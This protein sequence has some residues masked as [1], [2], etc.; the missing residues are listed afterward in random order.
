[1]PQRKDDASTDLAGRQGDID[2]VLA[3]ATRCLAPGKID[4]LI[5]HWLRD[6]LPADD[7][8]ADVMLTRMA[9]G[10]AIG[11]TLAVFTPSPSGQTAFDRLARQR[12]VAP[13]LV[14]VLDCLRRT[15][16]RVV[17]AESLRGDGLADVRDVASGD[18]LRVADDGFRSEVMGVRLA[19]WVVPG[20]DDRHVF[21]GPVVPLDDPAFAVVEAFLRTGHR[22]LVNPLRCAD[23]VYQHVVHHGPMRLPAWDDNDLDPFDDDDPLAL[24][25]RKWARTPAPRSSDD[26]QLV[27][28]QSDIETVVCVLIA[29]GS[30][31][32][33]RQ[34]ALAAA[35]TE[36]G[37]V[38]SETIDRRAAIS[39]S[40]AGLDDLEHLIGRLIA[41]KE[42]PSSVREILREIRQAVAGRRKKT[43]SDRRDDLDDVIARIQAL[44]VRTVER[45]C[46]EQEVLA[47]AEKAAELL[48]RH[49]L[50]LSDLDI[51]N[52]TCEAI[53]VETSRKRAGALD[54][55]V[56][57]IAAIFDTRVW[58]ET[59]EQGLLRHVFF[60]LPADVQAARYLYEL[61]ERTFET[62]GAGF[63]TSTA[64]LDTAAKLR[65]TATNSFQ[66]GLAHGI[67]DK[68]RTLRETRESV[69]RASSGRDLVTVKAD[70]V[71]EE[72]AALGLRLYTR[73]RSGRRR[74]LR[75]VYDQGRQTGLDFDY[76][77]GIG[78]Q[79]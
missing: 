58:G 10:L 17:V 55:C 28:A 72:M 39:P 57:T 27:R 62:E 45:G 19:V 54:D 56:P 24:L 52:Q 6:E 20:D 2:E 22:G 29:I 48:D 47:A 23:A 35:W 69:L 46:T 59:G 14:P 51:R 11:T 74:M 9:L 77:P 43:A 31:R 30:A 44:R 40:A 3:S 26:I 66:H 42:V 36:I 50:S 60:G 32:A 12:R 21:V 73:T 79:G 71:D 65:R 53:I 7:L 13:P 70:V 37:Q 68:L 41:T 63:R 8:S 5:R 15:R 61:V 75:D 67:I 76:R 34:D 16:F 4:A 1:M 33:T 18:R 64:Y 25:A 78:Q 49:G 38:Q